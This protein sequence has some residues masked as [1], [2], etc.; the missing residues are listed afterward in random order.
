MGRYQADQSHRR[1][2]DRSR[3][4]CPDASYT[5]QRKGAQE[6][7]DQRAGL[8][9][10]C[11]H[12][13]HSAGD[14]LCVCLPGRAVYVRPR[15][16]ADGAWQRDLLFWNSVHRLFHRHI[17]DHHLHDAGMEMQKMADHTAF[18]HA[19]TSD[20]LSFFHL[21]HEYLHAQRYTVLIKEDRLG[22]KTFSPL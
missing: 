11:V 20:H 13:R 21:R 5:L 10:Y 3:V 16:L 19:Y 22:C 15:H 12:R 4:R 8:S 17:R 9:V 2:G 18:S 7:H 14:R 1:S 6:R